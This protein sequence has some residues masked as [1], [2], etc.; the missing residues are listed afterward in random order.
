MKKML[1]AISVL[2][3]AAHLGAQD[4]VPILTDFSQ[5]RNIENQNWALCQDENQIMLFA[6]R[7]GILTFD[8]EEWL[9]I[10]MPVVPYSLQKNPVDKRIYL[11][12]D[13]H[14]GYITR[15]ESESWRYISL[16]DNTAGTG[17]ITKIVF[18]TSSV[19]FYSEQTIIQYDTETDTTRLRLDARAGFPFTGLIVM[20]E[21]TYVN[22]S[23]KGLHR[24]DSDTL[25][26]IVTGYLTENT[27]ILFSLP[28]NKDLM[29]VGL[30]NGTLSLFDGMKY[31][32]YPLKDDGYLKQNILSEGISLADTAYAFS[33]LEG[34][35]VIVRKNTG[36]IIFTINN[37]NG[38]PDDEILAIGS[39]NSGGL[40]LSHQYGL[41][42]ADL[43]I[44]V[45]SFCIYPGLLGNLTSALMYDN[46]LYVATSEGVFYLSE[47]RSYDRIEV[48]VR[49]DASSR[50]DQ[51]FELKQEEIQELITPDPDQ[52]KQDARRN[53]FSR[54]FGK[55]AD[56]EADDEP[57]HVNPEE[58]RESSV[59][60][61]AS[62][63]GSYTTKTVDRLRE[64]N[65]I[66]KKVE[67]LNEKCRQLVPIP[68]GMLAATNKGLYVIRQH[69]AYL[70]TPNRYINHIS[71]NAS[72]DRYYVS[73]SDGYFSIVQ[74]NRGWI[75]EFP[76]DGFLRPVYSV[77][78]DLKGSLWIGSDNTVY[79]SEKG[80]E[81][82]QNSFKK[83]NVEN[84]YPER[85]TLDLIN[86]T[87]FLFTESEIYFFD[88]EADSFNPC[89]EGGNTA[90]RESSFYIP[91][92]NVN[93]IWKGDE[94]ISLD[95]QHDIRSLEL[96]LLKIFDDIVSI[97]VEDNHI[98][99]IDGS[100]RLY[101]I[102]RNTVKGTSPEINVLI[103]NISNA[104][105]TNF[106]L[107][108][109]QF[110][111]GDNIIY[112]DIV[113][114]GYLKNGTTKYQYFIYRVMPDWSEWSARTHYEVP[115]SRPGDY[116]LQVRAR[117]LWGNISER[118]SVRFTIK[119]P[120]TR[121]AVF[122][123]VSGILALSLI[124]FII[125]FRERQLHAKT[126]LLEKRVRERTAQIEAQ[127]GE[128]TSS[129]EYA[130]RIQ[131]AMLHVD[132]HF[133]DSFSDYFIFFRPRDIV[134]GDFYWISEDDKS[135]FFTV[136]DCTGHGV[137]GAFMSTMGISTL[138]EIVAN[139]HDLQANNVLNLLREKVIRALHQT[140]RE[141]EASDG[142][143]VAFCILNKNRRLLQYS[144][145]F[146]P[147]VIF[148]QG[149]IREFRADRMPIGIHYGD[150]RP[151]TN[152]VISVNRGDTLYIFSDGFNSQFGGPGGGKYKSAN[153]K[154]LLREIY[155]RPMV[156]QR[157]ILQN[158]L[159]QWMGN[160]DQTDDVT[161]IGIRI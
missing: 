108:N 48:L 141:G 106:D 34:G 113:A 83:Y 96:S 158:E 53:I 73:T 156:E 152:N 121:T 146:N 143:D 54:I 9:N 24:I 38:L 85:F 88:Y 31:Y 2:F 144:G 78:D 8:G 46:E 20:P 120:L 25:F 99:V 147:L 127:K 149:E 76:D 60:V 112:F 131:K 72:K 51:Q 128:I 160:N 157:N 55:R 123:I 77:T 36:E 61:S 116:I 19:W 137:P 138:N 26:P 90:F 98:W 126:R 105:G 111:R 102:R 47:V 125:R 62:T 103:K 6:N 129:I 32:D 41:T 124:V 145:A 70:L 40:W 159:E 74:K 29:L 139:N 161:I 4:G 39:D 12:G 100:N 63:T 69:K 130:G 66:Y 135:I 27:S 94:W 35:A 71:W 50:N 89:R 43:S 117:D 142:M 134:S 42:R 10:R 49:D 110:D 33:T 52:G 16:S 18:G 118:R 92:S 150:E 133:R 115:I 30:G 37:Q 13:N 57:D 80:K 5:S 79:R 97:T 15:S 17:V 87:L 114:P 67:G 1:L 22:V 3:T 86:D 101:G 14:F 93:L 81:N 68:G 119:A 151:F 132:E 104:R 148:Q 155:Y 109:V 44:P 153:L 136:A 56:E 28:Y 107:Q 58:G 75:T 59:Y 64:I 95:P 122:Y 7:K 154:K 45:R 82:S 84:D 21:N 23:G 91:V 65:H 140:G 11:G